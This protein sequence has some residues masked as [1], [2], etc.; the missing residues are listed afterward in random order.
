MTA[1]AYWK[2][3]ALTEQ[4]AREETEAQLSDMRAQL[5]RLEARVTRDKLMPLVAEAGLADGGQWVPDDEKQE[6]RRTDGPV[7]PAGEATTLAAE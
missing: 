1:A 7:A 3:R 2:I 4:A 5:S 6:F